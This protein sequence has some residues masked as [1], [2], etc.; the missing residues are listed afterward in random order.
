MEIMA[1]EGELLR[2][3]DLSAMIGKFYTEADVWL[4]RSCATVCQLPVGQD[5]NKKNWAIKCFQAYLILQHLF[6]FGNSQ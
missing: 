5:E 4:C 3:Q 6:N 2:G 1:R